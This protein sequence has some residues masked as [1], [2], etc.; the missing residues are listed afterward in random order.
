LAAGLSTYGASEVA[1]SA[2]QTQTKRTALKWGPNEC[3]CITAVG[4]RTAISRAC[5]EIRI[6]LHPANRVQWKWGV[7]LNGR[8]VLGA[9]HVAS[10]L[11]RVE[12]SR[13]RLRPEPRRITGNG[14]QARR[15]C[16]SASPLRDKTLWERRSRKRVESLC[17]AGDINI[18]THLHTPALGLVRDGSGRRTRGRRVHL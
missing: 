18:M 13:R 7:Q 9:V 3:R 8:R 17:T 6:D 1:H 4:E 2:A 16:A 5:H 12:K 15:R 11:Q 10:L 14:A